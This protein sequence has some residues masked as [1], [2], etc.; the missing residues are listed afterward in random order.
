MQISCQLP[1]MM[2]KFNVCEKAGVGVNKSKQFWLQVFLRQPL[3]KKIH[4]QIY[5]KKSMNIIYIYIYIY[6][7][8]QV[9]TLS[10]PWT[11]RNVHLFWCSFYAGITIIF[12]CDP[13][14]G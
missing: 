4:H 6:M 5:R 3:K 10:L 8:T 7:H 9:H 11:F 2:I 1:L 12:Y 13:E 14:K